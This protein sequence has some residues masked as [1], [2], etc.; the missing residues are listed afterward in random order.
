MRLMHVGV[1][2]APQFSFFRREVL[3]DP[4]RP[5]RNS[6]GPPY[7][8]GRDTIRADVGSQYI[9]SMDGLMSLSEAAPPQKTCFADL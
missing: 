5:H 4:D 1:V 6:T 8:L 3:A 9:S 2:R 7:S